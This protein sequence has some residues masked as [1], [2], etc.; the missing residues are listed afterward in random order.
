[1]KNFIQKNYFEKNIFFRSF[2]VRHDDVYSF[3]IITNI[4]ASII[5]TLTRVNERKPEAERNELVAPVLKVFSDIIL[6]V[7]E[8]RR[9]PLYVKLL[10]TL[11]TENYLW[12]FVTILIESHVAHHKP[13]LEK[14][15][16]RKGPS[17]VVEAPQR[18]E[19]ALAIAK[20][21]SCKTIIVT[22]TKMLDFLQKL[23]VTKPSN[24]TEKIPAEIS[25]LFN[26]YSLPNKQFR[27]LKYA[28]VMFINTLTSSVEFVN[29][30]ALLSDEESAA[31]KGYYQDAILSILTY[32]PVVSKATE[33][34]KQHLDYWKALLHCCFDI[35]ENF[36]S[37]LSSNVLLNVVHELLSHKLS[38]VR[39]RVVELL[40]NKLQHSPEIFNVEND[41]GLVSLLGKFDFGF[42]VKLHLE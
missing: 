2:Q 40:V 20:E 31:M 12:M 8:H 18:V 22:C 19:I 9:L 32:I 10:E 3:Q 14:P 24:E 41:N 37:L 23:P 7:P 30:V 38:S 17:F 6:D 1:M 16:E 34:V 39:R 35:L 4:I 27:H 25:T 36:I 29:K 42:L 33:Q 5:P 21:F 13:E 15:V 11:N 28:I 26:L